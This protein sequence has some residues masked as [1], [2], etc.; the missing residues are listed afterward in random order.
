MSSS[1]ESTAATSRVVATYVIDSDSSAKSYSRKDRQKP[2]SPNRGEKSKRGASSPISGE[3]KSKRGQHSPSRGEKS[4]RG[5][6]RGEKRDA[7]SPMRGE[8]SKRPGV[9]PVVNEEDELPDPEH[10]VLEEPSSKLSFGYVK[11][12][13]KLIP[14]RGEEKE[15]GFARSTAAL[16]MDIR[17]KDDNPGTED[18]VAAP[19]PRGLPE[20]GDCDGFS[21]FVPIFTNRGDEKPRSYLHFH[22]EGGCQNCKK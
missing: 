21:G 16:P 6:I 17:P 18:D 19:F 12:A 1:S 15:R 14:A 5:Q 13:E 7:Q 20:P 8:K 11:D 10:V 9:V 2:K 22:L 3:R 4:K